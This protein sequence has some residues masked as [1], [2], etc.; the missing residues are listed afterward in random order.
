MFTIKGLKLNNFVHCVI[1][2]RRDMMMRIQAGNAPVY[3][4]SEDEDGVYS[5][6]VNVIPTSKIGI[7]D[8]GGKLL[9]QE[10][11]INNEKGKSVNK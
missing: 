11:S 10:I 7:I 1:P 2:K 3:K 5:D 4:I 8:Y 9:K 6:P